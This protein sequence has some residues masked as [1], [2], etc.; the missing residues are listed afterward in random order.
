MS[1]E[2]LLQA[3]LF[4]EWQAQQQQQKTRDENDKV[5]LKQ[6]EEEE[7]EEDEKDK[8]SVA[9]TDDLVNQ[10]P[11]DPASPPAP[12]PPPPPPPP[13]PAP[14]AIIPLSVVTSTPQPVV[15]KPL[16][17]PVVQR[18]PPVISP[19]VLNKEVPI[20]PV[21]QRPAGPMLPDIK[22]TPLSIGS[23]K[24]LHHYQA[25]VLAITHHHLMQ[26]QQPP[27]Q[28]HQQPHQQ[29][30]IQ[31]QP[32]ALP[33]PHQPP[34]P[35]ALGALRLPTLDDGRPNEQR[36]RP[37]GRAHLKEC[38]ETLK[39]NIPNVDDKKT[40]NLSVL[41]SALRYIQSLKRKEKEYEH[42]MERLARE[43]IATQQ[44]LADLKN[45]LS[46]WMDI[47]EIDR[48]VRQTVQPEDD[49]ASTSTASEGEDNIDEDMDDDRLVNSLT[50]R[51]QPEL[52]KMVPSS[53]ASHNHHSTVL[54]QHVSIQQKQAP[55]P[56][57][58]PQISN[59]SL[60]PPQALLPT[61]THIVAASTVQS[62]VIAHTATTHASVIQTL[63]HVIP[64]PQTKHI[65]HIAPSTSSPVQ[66]T[67][68]AQPIG[69]ITV[70]PATINHM[71]HLGQPL[72]IYPQSVAVS[73]PMVSHIAH[74]ITHPQVNGTTNLGQPAVMAKPAV[75]TQVVHHSQLVG[76]TVLNPVTMVTMPSF[77][78]STL[79]LA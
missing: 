42:E 11:P 46:Q 34:P 79:K 26:Q 72:P 30:P 38:F 54:P 22:T 8:K 7:E 31:P 66:L 75:G 35:Q 71:T 64:G 25:P 48:I 53:A 69:H 14:V 50:K 47:L 55:S 32:T 58:Q 74:T 20:A 23:P 59:Q 19:P 68:A 27:Q 10:A 2:T 61:Q 40:S 43:K 15:Q 37:G 73:Q 5:L 4:L 49:Q 16:S 39:R 60:V 45:E 76:Q 63:N 12:A 62:T 3:A 6:E 56:H 44:R 28:P 77:P 41:R 78:V 57:A 9:R 70:H 33:H 1:L 18:H 52:L 24:Q 17:P 36:R 13:L 29:Q 21:I 65:A 67:T 51:Q